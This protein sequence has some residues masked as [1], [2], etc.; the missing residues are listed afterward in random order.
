MIIKYS[1]L[2]FTLSENKVIQLFTQINL[3]LAQQEQITI[4]P[5]NIQF[6]CKQGRVEFIKN[7]IKHT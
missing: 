1:Y 2:K 5:N 4:K 7:F 6:C 3:I